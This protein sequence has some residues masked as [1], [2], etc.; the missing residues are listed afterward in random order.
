MHLTTFAV[1][2]RVDDTGE[3]SHRYSDRAKRETEVLD[4]SIYVSRHLWYEDYMAKAWHKQWSRSVALQ[5]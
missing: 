2:Y 4:M 1:K 3:G 5:D